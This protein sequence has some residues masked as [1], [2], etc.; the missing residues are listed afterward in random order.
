MEIAEKQKKKI[1]EIARKYGLRL[2]LLFGSRVS[3]RT[4]K[5][6]DYDVAYLPEKELTG[7][8]EIQL[9]YEFTNIFQYDRV[10][11]VDIRK[12][13]PLLLYAVFNECQILYKEDD[14]IFPTRRAYAFK[15]Y[16]EAKPMLEKFLK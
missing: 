15:K 3:G 10:D 9:N 13:P 12:A 5:E 4:H 7:E 8:E 6:S 1:E 16:I 2:V 14:L 11:T